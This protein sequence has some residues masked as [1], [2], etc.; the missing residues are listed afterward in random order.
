MTFYRPILRCSFA[1]AIVCALPSLANAS[2]VSH[3]L[4]ALTVDCEALQSPQGFPLNGPWTFS[5]V[6]S[7]AEAIEP[8]LIG[9]SKVS[10]NL[11]V[12]FADLS[13]H[14]ELF[15]DCRSLV[16]AS[17]TKRLCLSIA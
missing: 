4:S 11:P 13:E 3:T 17:D 16:V 14:L 12:S 7:P 2:G 5:S 10:L 9:D 6:L 15:G 1:V 8:E